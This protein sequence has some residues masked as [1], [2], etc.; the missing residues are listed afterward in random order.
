MISNHRHTV[1]G[2]EYEAGLI[3]VKVVREQFLSLFYDIINYL[4]VLHIFLCAPEH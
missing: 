4:D 3:I 2:S 1:V